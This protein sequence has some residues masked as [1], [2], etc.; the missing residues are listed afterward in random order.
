MDLKNNPKVLPQRKHN[1]LELGVIMPIYRHHASSETVVILQGKIQWVSYDQAVNETE[2][3]TLY[4][5]GE[6]RMINIERG[7]KHSLVCLESGSV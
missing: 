2:R 6:P 1:D 3:V 4:A 7:R 5:N